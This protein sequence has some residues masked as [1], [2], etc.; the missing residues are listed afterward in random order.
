VRQIRNQRSEIRNGV[1]LEASA[2]LLRSLTLFLISAFCS[3]ICPQLQASGVTWANP[4]TTGT[5]R[6]T[7]FANLVYDPISQQTYFYTN[8]PGASTIY[9][10][11]LYTYNSSNHVFTHLGGT[12]ALNDQCTPDTSTQPGER[13]PG[14]TFWLDSVGGRIVQLGGNNA[15]CTSLG[16][17]DGNPRQDMYFE[18]I[19]ATPSLD[20]H[21]ATPNPWTLPLNADQY[22]ATSAPITDTTHHVYFMFGGGSL[23]HDHW[24]YCPTYANPTPGTLTSAQISVGCDAGSTDNWE[25]I[26]NF[27]CSG[28]DCTVYGP[29]GNYYTGLLYSPGTDTFIQGFGQNT[30]AT[31]AFQLTF[32]G[33]LS[34]SN[35]HPV[36]TWTEIG[37]N[38]TPPNEYP[39]GGPGASGNANQ[40]EWAMT[41]NGIYYH[42][43]KGA[44][45][46]QDWLLDPVAGT[47]TNLGNNGGPTSD[48]LFTYD[49]ST[50]KLIAQAGSASTPA[51]IWEGSLG[52]VTCGISPGGLSAG[53]VGIAYSQ[54]LTATNCGSGPFTWTITAGSLP[55]GLSG[56]NGF[57]GPSCT[58]SGT[59]T[60]ASGSPFNFTIQAT[61]G[62]S[63]TTSQN[64]SLTVTVPMPTVATPQVSPPTDQL[65]LNG[66]EP[67][68]I[69][70]A[71]SG[72]L[73]Y[74]T[75]DGS[76][77]TQSSTL[78]PN[79]GL[80]LSV[81]TILK[82]RAFASGFNPSPVV[83]PIQFTFAAAAGTVA[84]PTFNPP[85]GSFTGTGSVQI[86]DT[87]P[88]AYIYYTLDGS[89]P[90]FSSPLYN[91]LISLN[92]TTTVKAIAYVNG[93]T[94]SAMGSAVFTQTGSGGGT[95]PPTNPTPVTYQVSDLSQVKVY[96]NPWRKDKH[97]NHPMITFAN[98]P[99]GATV[100]LF[101]TSGHEVRALGEVNGQANWDL[102]NKSGD[103]VA[104]GI[105]VYLITVGDT[106][107]G[108]SAQKLKGKVAVIK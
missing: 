102:M 86:L 63:N 23:L 4:S 64:Y 91:G 52:P 42:Q 96:P 54:I 17:P 87:T 78:Y 56:C 80:T 22:Q 38:G 30:P 99:I 33:K 79:S 65:N 45:A 106:G 49:A 72:A 47:W 107:Y 90:T 62:G 95:N 76:D 51:I 82:V 57:S 92:Q 8:V 16:G 89:I 74:Y 26:T 60:T 3:L 35:G 36:M 83:G 68:T 50:N 24:L 9:S 66:P 73:I 55:P 32:S 40:P 75:T 93:M 98:L 29:P 34:A 97:A 58:I 71:T 41:P 85:G 67:V 43:A 44:N 37:L 5:P 31:V 53:V 81:N 39:V 27:T 88:N 104:S 48:T 10:S 7:G 2:V 15:S 46:P 108:G 101:T 103:K 12:G 11:D 14:L 13:H 20:W 69:T 84:T 77:P 19:H 59:P 21:V 70:C 105:Y 18:Y 28:P 6:A 100:K 1:G 25:E 94:I 61:D